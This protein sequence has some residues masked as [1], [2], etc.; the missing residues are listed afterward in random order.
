MI[1][2]PLEAA[3]IIDLASDLD[4]GGTPLIP[5]DE[6]DIEDDEEIEDNDIDDDEDEE[7]DE[8]DLA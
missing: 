8:H 2:D 1:H 3:D 6:E 4:E 7:E 5:E